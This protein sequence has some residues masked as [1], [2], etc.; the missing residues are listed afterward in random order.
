M[1]YRSIADLA[2]LMRPADVDLI[3]GIPRSGMLP[4]TMLALHLNRKVCD[5][6]ALLGNLP[7][8]HGSTRQSADPQLGLPQD[9]RHIFVIDDS[10]NSGASMAQAR[11]AQPAARPSLIG[12]AKHEGKVRNE[13][14]EGNH[15]EPCQRWGR[16]YLEAHAEAKR[17]AGV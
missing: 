8:R 14:A 13:W 16:A 17:R 9:A 2:R 12:P 3:V 6:G 15:L 7:L 10:V 4:A 11:L 5:L 1:N